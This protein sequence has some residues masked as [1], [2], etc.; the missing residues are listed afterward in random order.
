[1]VPQPIDVRAQLAQAPQLDPVDVAR[2]VDVVRHESGPFENLQVLR[3]RWA[4]DW[5]TSRDLADGS[6]TIPQMLEDRP[7]GRVCKC[8]E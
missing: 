6:G 8:F 3:H 7:S 1:L 4:T 5:Q 2:S